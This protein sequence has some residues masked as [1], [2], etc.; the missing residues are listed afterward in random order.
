MPYCVVTGAST[1]IGY[2]S[3]SAFISAGWSVFSIVR[4]LSDAELLK[5][6]FGMNLVPIIA[7]VTDEESLRQAARFIKNLLKEE[8]LDCI[9]CNAG[10][11][12]SAPLMLMPLSQLDQLYAVNVRGVLATIQCFFPL[13]RL[14]DSPQRSRVFLVSSV[15]GRFSYPFLGAYSAS[16][17]A[18]EALGDALRREMNPSSIDVVLIE[19]GPIKTP[20]WKKADS[21]YTPST[22]KGTVWEKPIEYFRDFVKDCESRGL[23]SDAVAALILKVAT[24]QKKPRARYV[25]GASRLAQFFNFCLSTSWIDWLVCRALGLNKK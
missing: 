17:Y 23:C 19:P 18:L 16:K 7:D 8:A 11:A 5:S 2:A 1:G 12:F 3:A 25:I 22:A 6:S 15:S 21:A 13:L 9:I 14:S 10:I 24:S 20:L 4:N